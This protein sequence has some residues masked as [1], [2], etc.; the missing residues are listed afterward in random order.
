MAENV[1]VI[2]GGAFGTRNNLSFAPSSI[3]VPSPNAGLKLK[4]DH[5]AE[6]KKRRAKVE[7]EFPPY[8]RPLPF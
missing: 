1:G 3:N 5:P 7:T 8:L 4:K 2:Y 6:I